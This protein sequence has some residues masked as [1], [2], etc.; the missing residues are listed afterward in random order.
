MG[1][2]FFDAAADLVSLGFKVFPIVPGRKLPLIK[3]WQNAASDGLETITA[4]AS[5]WPHANIGIATGIMSGVDVIDIDMKDGKNGQATLD[6]L[7]RQGKAL[8][9]S[10]TA[11]TPT[12][13]I[14]RFFRAVPGIRNVVGVSKDGRG[15]GVGIDVRAE[16][17]LVVAP[18]SELTKCA[19]HGAGAYRW[20]VPPMTAEFPRLPDWAVKMLMPKPRPKPTFKP[21]ARGGDIEPVARFVAASPQGQRNDRLYWAAR[22]ARELVETRAV[23]ERAVAEASA[24]RRLGEAAAAAGLPELEAMRTIRSGLRSGN[25]GARDDHHHDRSDL[26]HRATMR[27]TA[28]RDRA[29]QNARPFV[30]N[31]QIDPHRDV[32]DGRRCLLAERAYGGQD[33]YRALH[34][35]GSGV[36]RGAPDP[37][38]LYRAD[39]HPR[40]AGSVLSSSL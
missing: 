23:A 4:W 12:G 24:E 17:G 35:A 18:P 7:S 31:N 11:I 36:G 22:R 26:H 32:A 29:P 6:A 9:P 16:G 3:A 8:P 25:Q 27:S 34:Q 40:R 2:N 14:H 28:P 5:Q 38:D 30:R 37:P 15:I 20:L 1:M 21:D 39:D 19:A 33:T 13:G 10:P